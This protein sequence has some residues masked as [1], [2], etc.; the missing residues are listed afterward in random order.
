MDS[1]RSLLAATV[2]FIDHT[3]RAVYMDVHEFGYTCQFW[4]DNFSS[5]VKGS[6][7]AENYGQNGRGRIT[8]FIFFEISSSRPDIRG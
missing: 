5:Q 6:T 4:R 7:L 8:R 3:R 1:S 2:L